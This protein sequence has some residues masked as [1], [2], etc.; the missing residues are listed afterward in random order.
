MAKKIV[1]LPE[2]ADPTI[3]KVLDEF[4]AD[5]RKWLKPRTV[6]RRVLR[7]LRCPCKGSP[8]SLGPP[9]LNSILLQP[10]RRETTVRRRPCVQF[11]ASAA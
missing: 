9:R 8:G 3:E 6:K 2:L 1:D 7:L 5:Q 4:L 10:I 11:A